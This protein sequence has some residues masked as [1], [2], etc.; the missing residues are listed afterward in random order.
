MKILIWLTL[1]GA[2]ILI[3]M[4]IQ[5]LIA[6]NTTHSQWCGNGWVTA[7]LAIIICYNALTESREGE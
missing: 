1:I 2:S 5:I 6:G 7:S 3:G 4:M